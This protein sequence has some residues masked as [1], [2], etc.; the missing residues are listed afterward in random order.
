M[1]YTM[2]VQELKQRL[3]KD[4]KHFSLMSENHTNIP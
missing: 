1:A 4:S 3:E 2:S